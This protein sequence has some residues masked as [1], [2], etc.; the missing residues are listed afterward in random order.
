MIVKGCPFSH[1]GLRSASSLSIMAL[2]F[3]ASSAAC[4]RASSSLPFGALVLPRIFVFFG[5]AS[6]FPAVSTTDEGEGRAGGPT[7]SPVAASAS[8]A[9][10]FINRPFFPGLFFGDLRRLERLN[11]GGIEAGDEGGGAPRFDDDAERGGDAIV[12]SR[13]SL[14]S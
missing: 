2:S 9:A 4:A 3:S 13:P 10:A 7:R 8:A 5:F 6:P 12:E 1:L 11:A 14:A